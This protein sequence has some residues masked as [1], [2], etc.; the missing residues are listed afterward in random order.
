MIASGAGVVVKL[1]GMAQ[2]GRG[3]LAIFLQLLSACFL[4]IF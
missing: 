4:L 1:K 2:L 3:L